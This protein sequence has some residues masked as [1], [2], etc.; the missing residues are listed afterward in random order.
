MFNFLKNIFSTNDFGK[1]SYQWK[2]V[3]DEF[4][5]N[6]PVCAACG[7]NKTLEVHHIKPYH[8]NPELELDKNNLITLCRDHHYTFGHFCDW[9]SWNIDVKTD[10]TVYNSKRMIRPTD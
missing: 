3:R 10:T 2:K 1:R 7:T 8:L 6:N 4:I 9:R 5:S